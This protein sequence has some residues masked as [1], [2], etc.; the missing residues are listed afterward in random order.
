MAVLGTLLRNRRP[1]ERNHAWN[2][3]N[4]TGP[5]T[6]TI[7]SRDFPDNG[8]LPV[9]HC[10]TRVGGQNLSPHLTWSAPPTG[11]SE[12]LLVVEDID[13]PLGSNPAIHCLAAIDETRLA[14][15][16]ELPPGALGKNT[17]APGVT[18]LRSFISR[19]YYGPEPLKGHGP[20]RYVFELY[21]LGTPL[22]D[23]PDRDAL[24]KT[25]P[26]RLLAAVDAPV[27]ARGRI[28][29]VSER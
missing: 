1:H 24:L 10:G 27:L 16:H 29:G 20:H 2:Q 11:T 15:P 18:L 5:P 17:P 23:R 3:A 28:T 6:L 13:V 4:L 19:G 12:L 21:A 7:T 25:R 22:L 26:R 8:T 9:K 14:S